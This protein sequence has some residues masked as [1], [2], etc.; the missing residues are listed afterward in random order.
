VVR[1]LQCLRFE[2]IQN[3]TLSPSARL[4]NI[5]ILSR[6]GSHV[7]SQVDRVRNEQ[8]STRDVRITDGRSM[9]EV[10]IT[11]YCI[12]F[13]KLGGAET[14]LSITILSHRFVSSLETRYVGWPI[15]VKDF[16]PSSPLTGNWFDSSEISR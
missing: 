14:Y 2:G 9:R 13:R 11:H 7:E 12:P 15:Q 10:R 4:I 16:W 8:S 5:N 3:G 6:R 1:P